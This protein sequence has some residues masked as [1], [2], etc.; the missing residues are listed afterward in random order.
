[1]WPTALSS[2]AVAL[3]VLLLAAYQGVLFEDP[4]TH[5]FSSL[6]LVMR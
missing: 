5:W 2:L 4:L 6:V 1:M 3:A